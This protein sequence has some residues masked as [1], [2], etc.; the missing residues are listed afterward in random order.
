MV[1]PLAQKLKLILITAIVGTV[2][3][4]LGA[5]APAQAA[6]FVYITT[7]PEYPFGAGGIFQYDAGARG[8]L[9]PL[10]PP[11]VATDTRPGDAV[12]SPDGKTLYVTGYSPPDRNDPTKPV[13]GYLSQFDIGADGTLSP[14]MVIAVDHVGAEAVSPDGKSLY[15]T[16]SSGPPGYVGQV[17]QYNVGPDGTL[18]AKSP[19]T[20]ATG[21]GPQDIAVSPDGASVYVSSSGSVYQYDVGAGGTLSAKNPPAVAIASDRTGIA[22]SPDGRSVYFTADAHHGPGD[23]VQGYVLQ[24][25]VG[26]HGALSPK[27]PAALATDIVPLDAAV[28]SP[29]GKSL[30]VTGIRYRVCDR[31]CGHG[32]NPGYVA[33]FDV[34][35]GGA[36]SPKNPPTVAAGSLAGVVAVSPDGKSLYVGAFYLYSL[37][38]YDIGTDGTLSPKSPPTPPGPTGSDFYLYIGDIAVSPA[39]VPTRKEQ[40]TK[41]GWRNFPQFKNQGQCIAF[42]HHGP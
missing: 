22:V 4:L 14:K 33:Q 35:A 34:G 30:Y 12:V 1:A 6:P 37:L 40:C 13:Q 25:N 29:D 27:T 31:S 11:R 19:P 5:A 10:T 23:P 32:F 28:V 39:P 21:S 3:S 8:L 18:S 16:A 20:V 2:A 41:G 7:S 38:Q 42:V 15:V 36:L 9:T 17:F 26:A 24:Y